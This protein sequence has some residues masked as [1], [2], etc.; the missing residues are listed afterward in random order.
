MTKPSHNAPVPERILATACDLFYRQGYRATGINQVIAESG[1]AKASFYAH[2][3]SKDDL[4]AAYAEAISSREK[5]DIEAAVLPLPTPRARFFGPLDLLP[6]WFDASG[7]RGCPFQNVI[8]ELPP[9]DARVRAVARRHRAWMR[10]FLRGLAEDLKS[11]EPKL[12]RLD[13]A[14]LADHYLLLFEGAMAVSVAYREAWPVDRARE[15]L[16]GW[17]GAG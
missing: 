13:C 14:A 5:A 16:T 4:L 7:Y 1:V 15:A 8:A 9:D 6:P 11:A 2:F 12:K 10:E 3:A 17:V